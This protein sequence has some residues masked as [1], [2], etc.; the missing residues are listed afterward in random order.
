M[1]F[2]FRRQAFGSRPWARK[3]RR[4]KLDLEVLEGRPLLS[5]PSPSY[6]ANGGTNIVVNPLPGTGNFDL[7]PNG[8]FE[9]GTMAGWSPD[10]SPAQQ[11]GDFVVSDF[12]YE[13]NFSAATQSNLP[14]QPSGA[15]YA[16]KDMATGLTP[17]ATYVLSGCM[18]QGSLATGDLRLDLWT[19]T[20]T[21]YS[22]A[23]VPGIGV[24]SPAATNPAN[25]I[26][27]YQSFVANASTLTV[28]MVYD[29]YFQNTSGVGYIDDVAITPISQFVPPQDVVPAITA[30]SLAF[31]T[32]QGGVDYSYTIS[33]ADL[34]QPAA[35]ALY[36]AP[37]STFDPTQDTLIPGSVFTTATTA[38]PAP[39]TGN[40]DAATLGTP[41]PGT[42]DLLFVVDPQ[43]LVTPPN[44]NKV[45]SLT[46]PLVQ[47]QFQNTDLLHKL[48]YAGQNLAVNVLATNASN[49]EVVGQETFYLST[50]QNNS[51]QGDM[52]PLT[53]TGDVNLDLQPAQ[54]ANLPKNASPLTVLVPSTIQPG[55]YYLKAT[56][57]TKNNAPGNSVD[58]SPAL[59]TC[60]NSVGQVSSFPYAGTATVFDK[61]VNS[62]K[63]GS[64][65]I[66]TINSEPGIEQFI[67]SNEKIEGLKGVRYYTYSDN[68]IPALGFGSDLEDKTTHLVNTAFETIINTYLNNNPTFKNSHGKPLTFQDFLVMDPDAYVNKTTVEAMF[69]SG[70]QN[71]YQ[72]VTT[73]YSHLTLTQ[74]GAQVAA[75]TDIA[76][77]VGTGGLGAYY[78]MN[79]DIAMNTAF[80]FACAGLELV[81]SIRTIQVGADRT[82]KDFYLLTSYQGVAALL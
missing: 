33:N 23:P 36:W 28:R 4:W 69:S 21:N 12:A 65:Q 13:G 51:I 50:N 24:L 56:F 30:T 6:Y 54:A 43:N 60:V 57:A 16:Y 77:N 29:T 26:F 35:A 80:G 58:V 34:P 71:A 74:D 1:R 48:L 42:K 5:G 32:T 44:S 14:S 38:Q 8:G 73:H 78:S 17:G 7:V 40:I 46:L 59:T 63:Q 41:P 9:T 53:V 37:T 22:Y 11:L 18:N 19:P 81:N 55:T 82:D 66:P 15:G 52:G 39:Y 76:Y 61:A 3:T 27:C 49:E 64:P 10:A 25:W 62:V 20:A 67:E 31:D 70:F 68:G 47:T 45:A 79:A 2:P 75:L 72:Y